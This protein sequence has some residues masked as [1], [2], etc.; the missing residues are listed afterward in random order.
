MER[1]FWWHAVAAQLHQAATAVTRKRAH[2]RGI[3]LLQ[4]DLQALA[5]FVGRRDL[6]VTRGGPVHHTVS[7]MHGG[8]LY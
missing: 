6:G 2:E 8:M 1:D 3:R 7:I 5:H 4:L